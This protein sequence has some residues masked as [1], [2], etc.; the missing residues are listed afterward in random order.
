M[1]KFSYRWNLKETT[2][3]KDKGKVFSCFACGGGSTM[4]YKLAGF[5]VLGCNEIDPKMAEAYKTNHNPKYCFVEPIQTFKLRDD[6]PEELYNLD[7]LDGSPP[8]SS[9]SIAGA[10]EEDWGKEK[11]FR[12]GQAEQVLDT[13]FF[14]FID[15][16]AKL[17]P[18][19]VVA[20]NVKGLLLGEA[21]SY[22]L[23]IL[24]SF[25]KAG[26]MVNYWLLDSSD[27]GVPQKRERVFFLAIRKDIAEPFLESVDMFT[28]APKINLQF[29]EKKIVWGDVID[30]NDNI[31]TLS[32]LDGE[33]W[34]K[35][36]VG[37]VDLSNISL[38]ERNILSRFNAKFLYKE[39][40]ANTI[41]GGEQCV[42]FD[43]K[44]N[45]NK[46]EL[47]DCGT[48]PH[49]YNFLTNKP[50][51]LIGMSVPPVMTAQIAT[52]IYEQWLSKINT[53]MCS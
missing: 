40:V 41:T 48:Y 46:Q 24:E 15:L 35:R 39:K 3:T 13:L 31:E 14:D 4:G 11:K 1:H 18:K 37:D 34:E 42:L 38:R 28:I 26:Y 6:L 45:R 33:L 44:R 32:K 53:S 22:V 47:C 23:K 21:K 49:D 2:F 20:E 16:A 50:E 29:N 8:C 17:K 9:F 7:I 19:I 52:R 30:E 25:D 5:D 51:Y 12:E 36:Q 27:M 43:K 10:R